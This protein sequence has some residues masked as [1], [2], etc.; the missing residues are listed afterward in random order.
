M[1]V[2]RYDNSP[3]GI[4]LLVMVLVLV[5]IAQGLSRSDMITDAKSASLVHL[6]WLRALCL[7]VAQ[8]SEVTS[9]PAVALMF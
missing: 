7:R 3:D 9:H 2:S 4:S 6:P 5:V 8:Q 1:F